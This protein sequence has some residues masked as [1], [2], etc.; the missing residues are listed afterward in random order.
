MNV[1]SDLFL[2]RLNAIISALDADDAAGSITIY[3]G[4]QPEPG[5]EL[6]GNLALAVW[7]LQQP[8]GELTEATLN[9]LVAN[10]AV[11]AINSGLG[12]WGRAADGAGLWVMDAPAGTEEDENAVFVLDDPQIFAGGTITLTAAA[13]TEL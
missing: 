5:G 12:V 9:L 4:A 8:S 11:L 1:R 6:S 7:T 10:A 13:I 3:S 2:V